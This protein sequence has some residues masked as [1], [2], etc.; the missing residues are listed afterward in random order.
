MEATSAGFHETDLRLAAPAQRDVLLSVADDE[1]DAM[2]FARHAGSV[3][4]FSE[5]DPGGRGEVYPRHEGVVWHADS[6]QH[7]RNP[8]R[9]F[10]RAVITKN[11]PT[12]LHHA[13]AGDL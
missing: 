10:L 4:R 12:E 1:R 3:S 7:W 6:V 2:S 8:W 9:A 11:R 5:V 13:G